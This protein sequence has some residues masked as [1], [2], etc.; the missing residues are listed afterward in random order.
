MEEKHEEL[1]DVESATSDSFIDDSDDDGPSISG[2]NDGLHL[3]ASEYTCLTEEEIDELIAELLEVESKAAEAQ[4]SLEDESLVKLEEE[5]RQELAQSLHGED[6]E[7]AVTDEMTTFR[8][9]WETVLDELEK[10]SAD[11]LEQLDG[12][13]VE[14]PSL[15]KWI[16]S[17]APDG[18]STEAWKKRTHWVGSQVSNDVTEFVSDAEKYLQI[19]RPEHGKILEEGASGYLGKKL[20]TDDGREAIMEKT[21]VDWCS[22]NKIVSGRSS[23]E[24]TFGSKN[25]ASVYLAS[26]PQQAA[27]LGSNFL[28]SMRHL[29]RCFSSARYLVWEVHRYKRILS[30]MLNEVE[31]IDD[32]DP[33][34]ADAIAN[35]TEADLSETQKKNFRKVKEEDDANIDRKL[36]L[37]LKQKRQINRYKQEAIPREVSSVDKLINGNAD[38]IENEKNDNTCQ[39]LTTDVHGC[40]EVSDDF[41]KRK[42][43]N[44]DTLS[45]SSETALPHLTE[46]RGSKRSHD[47]EELGIDNKKTRTIIIDSDDETH[48]ME[49]ETSICKDTKMEDSSLLEKGNGADS[50][51][52]DSTL[53]KSPDKNFLCT[54]CDK[55]AVVVRQHPLLKDPDCL[56]CYC[57]WCGGNKSL[58]S[59]RLCKMLFCSS[60][61]KRNLG[62]EFLLKVQV[63]GWQCCCCSPNI[64]HSLTLQLEKAMGSTYPTVSSSDSDSDSS[65]ADITASISSKRKRKKK[66]HR[67]LDDAELGEETKKKIAIEKERQERL[68]SL[69]AQFSK[70]SVF[71]S[72]LN[73]SGS[74]SENC[75]VEVLGDA[76][77][78]YIVNV[79]RE[80]GEEAVRIPPSISGKLKAHQVIL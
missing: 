79:V 7:K 6:L 8:E 33:F 43:V 60:C 72:S 17:Q 23:E 29:L 35:D 75:S 64:L 34:V 47:V 65:D 28:E 13:G 66:I 39:N 16:E 37:H 55:L 3:E 50:V 40:S 2:E 32:I 48:T 18:C 19:H 1:D 74:L 36:Q 67:I 58:L 20:F 42:P 63:S 49:D 62:E 22:F 80:K 12:A 71:T 27:E 77:T 56:E 70:K 26:T 24:N 52:A 14:L 61:V 9:E 69:E 25:W 38:V 68:K 46:P 45:V 11:L 15:Y 57:G 73:F 78:G 30:K 59:C 54:A 21:D 4:E 5:V 51:C 41:D 10:E 76:L 44:N 53:S 31:E